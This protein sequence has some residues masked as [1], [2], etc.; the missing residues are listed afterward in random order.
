MSMTTDQAGAFVTAALSKISEL[1]YAGATPTAFDMPMV[2]KVITEEGEQPNGNLTP[3]DEEIGLVVSKGLLALH[4]DLTIKF[5][6]GHELGHGTS[7]H[8]LSQVG[9]EGISG[10]ATEVIADLSAAYILVQLGSTWDAVIGSISTWRD[11]DIF[12]AHASGHH[13]PGDERVAHV[14]ALQGLIG[15][16]VAFKDAAYQI[17]NPLPRS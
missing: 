11:T 1:F 4:D 13:P 7:L 9:L 5:A 15:K 16:K 8:I 14:R 10:Q 12:D 2:G 6:L 17:C 3:I